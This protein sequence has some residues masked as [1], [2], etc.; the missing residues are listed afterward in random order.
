MSGGPADA[1]CHSFVRIEPALES[2]VDDVPDLLDL[3]VPRCGS[4]C[5]GVDRS[6]CRRDALGE[7]D[8]RVRA[9]DEHRPVVAGGVPIQLV[10]RAYAAVREEEPNR[11][12]DA[13]ADDDLAIRVVRAGNIDVEA[14]RAAVVLTLFFN[15]K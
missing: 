10:E 1:D 15:P 13:V 11:V 9:V 14:S 8:A 5:T 12:G 7:Y 4:E 6:A 3:R 2:E